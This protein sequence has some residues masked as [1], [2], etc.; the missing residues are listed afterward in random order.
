MSPSPSPRPTGTSITASPD[1]RVSRLLPL[2]SV[3]LAAEEVYRDIS[4][5]EEGSPEEGSIAR[6]YVLINM[7]SSLD[8]K[9]AVEGK[10]GSIGSSIDRTLMRTLRAQADAVMIGAGTLRA[11]S[12]RLNVPEDLAR[13]RA[14]RGLEPQPLAVIATASGNIPL[15]ENLLGFSPDNLV[16]LASS[17]TPKDP[18]STL[19]RI[20]TVEVVPK[21]AEREAPTEENLV[22]DLAFA[23]EILREHYG[24]GVLL[25]EGGPA[26]NHALISS[27]LADELFLT[28]SPRLLGGEESLTILE[29]SILPS[30]VSHVRNLTSIYLAGDELFLRYTL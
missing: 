5:L 9:A 26:L 23:L 12:L 8:G 1:R 16:I 15:R 19:S 25:V 29:G 14:S 27:N 24:V 20:A 4:F 18:L 7:V 22:L 11:E 6:P 30:T 10:A 21:R 3:R 13:A 17:E 28:L 2:P